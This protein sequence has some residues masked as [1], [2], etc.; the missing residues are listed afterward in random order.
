MAIAGDMGGTLEYV[1]S[2]LEEAALCAGSAAE[3][4]G[5]NWTREGHS[6]VIRCET[7]GKLNGDASKTLDFCK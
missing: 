7:K 5:T 1:T 3:H 4:T 6:Q 2:W